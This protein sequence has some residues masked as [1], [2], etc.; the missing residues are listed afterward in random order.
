MTIDERL[1]ELKK[2]G[3]PNVEV[4][5]ILTKEGFKTP[6][7]R[8]IN[9]FWVN[10]RSIMLRKSHRSIPKIKHRKKEKPSMM[11]FQVPEIKP[12]NK[13]IAV[14]GDYEEIER[15]TRDWMN[16]GER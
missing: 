9:N 2:Q 10:N 6:Q 8:Q 14:M 11:T 5:E 15:L 1:M 12:K 7:D 4:A 16:H 13:M 3:L